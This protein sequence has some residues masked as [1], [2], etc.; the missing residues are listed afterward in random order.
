MRPTYSSTF[1]FFAFHLSFSFLYCY[2]SSYDIIET[3]LA[4]CKEP[5]GPRRG[6]EESFDKNFIKEG[7][8]FINS[9]RIYNI[10][11]DIV[12]HMVHT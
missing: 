10:L 2:E 5:P 4:Q 11:K 8:S 12:R 9:P 3:A 6:K 1:I 7:N